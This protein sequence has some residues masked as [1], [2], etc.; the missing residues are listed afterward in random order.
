MTSERRFYFIE[1]NKWEF[2]FLDPDQSSFLHL[3]SHT[4]SH[5]SS[6]LQEKSKGILNIGAHCHYC[7][8]ID[9]LPFKCD[10]CQFDYCQNHRVPEDHGCER[11]NP[12]SKSPSPAPAPPAQSQSKPP[13]PQRSGTKPQPSQ[14]DNNKPKVPG[15]NAKAKSSL[16]KL[17]S[18]FAQKKSNN[19]T[20]TT[21]TRKAPLITKHQKLTQLK[22]Q[23]VGDPANVPEQNRLYITLK[24]PESQYTDSITNTTQTRPEQV[25]TI[26]VDKNIVIGMLIDKACRQLD[27]TNKN[28]TSTAKKIALYKEPSENK[29]ETNVKLFECL[30]DGD[31]VTLK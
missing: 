7:E 23:A 29:L 26:F 24:R 12:V 30:N 10:L 20:T 5:M 13:I 22:K 6:E 2:F 15:D 4:L 14:A 28:N 9:F 17:K 27:V 25:K 31:I 1:F 19:T 21:T 3:H 8:Q 18:I 11:P 16:D